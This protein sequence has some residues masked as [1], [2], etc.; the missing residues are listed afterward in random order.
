MIL[1][2]KFWNERWLAN[3]TQWDIGYPSPAIVDMIDRLADEPGDKSMRI[4]IPGAGNAYE[5][6]YLHNKGFSNVY[7]VDY[8]EEALNRFRRRV[9]AFPESHIICSDFFDLN[10]KGF[11]LVIEQTFFCA[12]DPSLR[13]KY[14]HKMYE[15][16]NDY[17][18]LSG[19]LFTDTL[20]VEGPPFG[21]T[22]QEYREL[23]SKKFSVETMMICQNSIGP[24][25]GRELWFEAGK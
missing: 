19:L 6:E 7:V 21:G 4:L 1:D 2:D 24:R 20:G 10:E 18:F 5:A 11:E 25:Q 22:E 14:I 9:P 15:V 12:L 17:A 13:E 3:E 16:L 23:F 8:A